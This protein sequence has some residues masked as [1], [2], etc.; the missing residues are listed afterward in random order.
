MNVLFASVDEVDDVLK[1]VL[2]RHD[3]WK[4]SVNI[5][6]WIRRFWSNLKQKVDQQK[7]N[8]SSDQS[9]KMTLR[10]HKK[11]KKPMQINYEDYYL[12]PEE[13][14]STEDLL[15]K[16]AQSGEFANEISLRSEG[17]EVPNN[18]KIKK[19]LP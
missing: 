13:V 11:Q 7:Q 12:N 1:E 17:A 4:K 10:H 2:D 16:Y 5:I 14:T 15:F 6:A 19:L 3:N 18:S 9:R 8:K